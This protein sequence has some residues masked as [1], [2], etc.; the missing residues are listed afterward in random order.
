MD[1]NI[2][3]QYPGVAYSGKPQ[4]PALY[5]DSN[6][7]CI[8]IC[9]KNLAQELKQK[10]NDLGIINGLPDLSKLESIADISRAIIDNYEA[11]AGNYKLAQDADSDAIIAYL[12]TVKNAQESVFIGC[13]KKTNEFISFVSGPPKHCMRAMTTGCNN[14]RKN[15]AS[16]I[17]RMTE[18]G[19][20]IL[21]LTPWSLVTSMVVGIIYAAAAPQKPNDTTPLKIM[22]GTYPIVLLSLLAM[23][24]LC[25]DYPND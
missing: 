17:D 10:I 22:A 24:H 9:K 23:W 20:R 25:E 21:T 11:Q 16:S 4:P 3:R 7:V 19:V 15:Y 12:N 2:P 14:I 8:D 1:I 6:D 13:W 5:H 18:L